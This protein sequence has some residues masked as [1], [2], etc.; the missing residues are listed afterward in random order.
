MVTGDVRPAGPNPPEASWSVDGSL[1]VGLSNVGTMTI[2]DGGVVS[3]AT[4]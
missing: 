3:S 4:G 1:N 2:M